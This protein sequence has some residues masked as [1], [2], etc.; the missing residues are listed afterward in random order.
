MKRVRNLIPLKAVVLLLVCAASLPAQLGR[1]PA[2]DYIP[3][4]EDPGRL[5]RLNVDRVIATLQLEP[6]DVV[7]D[8]GAGSGVFTRRLAKA[9]APG[10]RVYAVDIDQELLD[11]NRSQIEAAYLKNTEF[12]RGDFDDPKLPAG[13]ID[14]VFICDVV[15][16]IEHRQ[17]Y[18]SKLR[19]SLKPGGRVAIIDYKT[20][21]PPGHESM[22]YTVDQLLEWMRVAGFKKIQEHDLVPNAFFY[23]F[24]P[25]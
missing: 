16:H 15:H 20:N 21:W 9:V 2:K 6:G 23:F 3:L 11:Y 24:S 12:I 4:L 7:A 13:A 19:E 17:A 8:V 10:G 14:L 1:R 22:Q 18:L 5:E 25:R